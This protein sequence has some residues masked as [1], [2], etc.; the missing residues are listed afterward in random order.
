MWLVLSCVSYVNMEPS[1]T[2]SDDYS[3]REV[4][5]Q[6]GFNYKCDL[7]VG[8][9]DY[10]QVQAPL[11]DSETNTMHR[12]QKALSQYDRQVTSRVSPNSSCLGLN[13]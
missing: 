8:F 9:V 4:S 5:F 6:R 13:G 3:P 11:D 7:R 1:S 2:I 10:A 12:E